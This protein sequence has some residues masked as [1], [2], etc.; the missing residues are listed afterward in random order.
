[1]TTSRYIRRTVGYFL[2]LLILVVVLYLLMFVTG[3]TRISAGA[4]LQELFATSRGLLLIGALVLLSAFYPT[5]G[6][7]KRNVKADIRTNRDDIINALHK[8]GYILSSEQPEKQMVFRADS[9]FKRLLVTFDDAVT[10]TA[11]DDG[12]VNIEGPRKSVVP[13]QFRI[14]TYVNNF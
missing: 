9:F 7:V 14:D 11:A 5:F 8:N 6:Y 1:M 4:M 10:V 13:I 12:T 3:S 2:K